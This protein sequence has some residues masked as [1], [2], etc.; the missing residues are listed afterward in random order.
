MYSQVDKVEDLKLSEN[1]VDMSNLI[2]AHHSYN[3]GKREEQKCQT[4]L[5]EFDLYGY[6]II[7]NDLDLES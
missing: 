3:R 7:S 1:S 5:F 2:W 6:N 4:K